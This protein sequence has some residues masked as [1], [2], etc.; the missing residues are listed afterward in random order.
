M[1][2]GKI[3]TATLVLA[4]GGCTQLSL[5]GAG[6]QTQSIATQAQQGDAEAQYQLGLHFTGGADVPQDY[7]LGLRHFRDA[8]EQGHTAAQ[9]MLGMGYY[10]GRGTAQDYEQARKWLELAATSQHREAMYYLGEIYLNGYGTPAAP[11]WGIY[12]IGQ[13]AELG[14]PP[15]QYL[16]GISLL[17][18]SGI[19]PNR[20]LGIAWLQRASQGGHLEA[21]A[22]LKKAGLSQR[23]AGAQPAPASPA[24]IRARY[25]ARYAQQRLNGLGYK[26]GTVDGVWGARSRNAARRFLS[27]RSVTAAQPTPEQMIPLLRGIAEH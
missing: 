24:H 3:A 15:A 22:L 1:N 5:V 11:A 10:V 23:A 9:Y 7:A 2:I 18:G 25:A 12:W 8:A 4:L 14:Y 21:R 20:S 16:F 19:A 26:V 13:A 27:E 17:S 6:D